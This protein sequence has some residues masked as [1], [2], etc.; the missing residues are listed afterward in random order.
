M[1]QIALTLAV[2]V[3]FSNQTRAEEM[4]TLP[5]SN[6]FV[7]VGASGMLF[8][9]K[10]ESS[11]GLVPGADAKIENNITPTLELGYYLNKNISLSVSSG[12]PVTSNIDA[13]APNFIAGMN[14]TQV[15]T[16]SIALGAQ[17]HLDTG[18]AFRPYAGVGVSY[19]FVM[20]QVPN[21][22]VLP[23]GVLDN[24]FGGILQAGA[25][26][27]ITEHVGLFVDVKKV[28]STAH[29]TGFGGVDGDIQLNPLVIS[30][31]VNLRF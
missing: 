2:V 8:D 18:G 21:P 9:S 25:D 20:D 10:L 5:M 24:N 23:D 19:N 16:G 22:L 13:I 30:S 6:W 1:K 28:F 11:V 7:H 3:A 12:L 27:D 26:L 17:Y 29:F 15:T 4:S 31:G 14:V